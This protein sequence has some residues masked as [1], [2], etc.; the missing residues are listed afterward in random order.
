MYRQYNYYRHYYMHDYTCTV[1]GAGAVSRQGQ[2]A[3]FMAFCQHSEDL[4]RAIQDPVA[5][6]WNLKSEGL[7]D[8]Q[9]REQAC[10]ITVAIEQRVSCL[11]DALEG[12]IASN[13]AAFDTFLS[14]LSKDPVVEVMCQT[15]KD[16]RGT[17]T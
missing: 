5:L 9:V 16:A 3:A 8:S 13:E 11:L 6:A 15:L 1:P 12:K 2:N 4:L 7:I 10:L 14:V 17:C